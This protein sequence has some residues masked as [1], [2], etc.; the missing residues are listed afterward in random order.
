MP[1]SIFSSAVCECGKKHLC[2][3]DSY[4]I[5]KGAINKLPEFIKRYDAKKAF[6]LA[7]VNTYPQAGDKICALLD[8]CGV[9]YS[10]YVFSQKSLGLP[11][12]L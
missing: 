7:D 12:L 5:E 1:D 9:D 8:E 6:I 3:V 4:I 2:T 11:R 10:K